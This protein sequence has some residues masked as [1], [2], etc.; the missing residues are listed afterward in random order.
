[1]FYSLRWTNGVVILVA[2]CLVY[3]FGRRN[4]G[5]H[6]VPPQ[7]KHTTQLIRCKYGCYHRTIINSAIVQVTN[8]RLKCRYKIY[9]GAFLSENC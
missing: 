8:L 9:P 6:V 4:Q 3:R 2:G 1:M 7:K 5:C